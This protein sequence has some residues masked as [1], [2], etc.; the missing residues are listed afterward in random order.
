MLNNSYLLIIELSIIY[1]YL[2]S[3][4]TVLRIVRV[5]KNVEVNKSRSMLEELFLSEIL[6]KRDNP[7]L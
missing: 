7:L 4:R 6:Q 2:Y 3:Q 1:S 5:E